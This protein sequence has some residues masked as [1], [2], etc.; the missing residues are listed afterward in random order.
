ME[1]IYT[2]EH[3]SRNILHNEIVLTAARS[4]DILKR[5]SYRI[6]LGW[7]STKTKGEKSLGINGF[8]IPD[9]VQNDNTEKYIQSH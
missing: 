2:N 5:S 4:H 6:L 7:I 9:I 1:E 8:N 3:L